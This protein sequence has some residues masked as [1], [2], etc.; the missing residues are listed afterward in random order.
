MIK[1]ET[2]QEFCELLG[3]TFGEIIDRLERIEALLQTDSK[4]NAQAEELAVP[5][6]EEDISGSNDSSTSFE[7]PESQ[8]EHRNRTTKVE[9]HAGICTRC[10]DCG[11]LLSML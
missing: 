1:E 5:A 4:A 9:G 11:W 8:C 10:A 3:K 7:G 2:I 6:E